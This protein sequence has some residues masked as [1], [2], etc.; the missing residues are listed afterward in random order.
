TA[1]GDRFALFQIA[2]A[3]LASTVI[4]LLLLALTFRRLPWRALPEEELTEPAQP[5]VPPSAKPDAYAESP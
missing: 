2:L 3:T 1:N 4:L 5:P